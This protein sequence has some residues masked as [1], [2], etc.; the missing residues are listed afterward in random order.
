[1]ALKIFIIFCATGRGIQQGAQH[2]FGKRVVVQKQ[3]VDFCTTTHSLRTMGISSDFRY[4]LN[5]Q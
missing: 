2:P 3:L 4:D 1:M 5:P